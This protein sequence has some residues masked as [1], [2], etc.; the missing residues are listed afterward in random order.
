[1]KPAGRRLTLIDCIP[2]PDRCKLV[3]P[4]QKMPPKSIFRQPGARHFQ[5]VHRSQRDPLIHDPDASNHV[6][7][8]FE[9][10]NQ[11]VC[12]PLTLF[13]QSKFLL[14]LK[15]C[16]SRV[17]PAPSLSLTTILLSVLER[18]R[19]LARLQAMESSSMTP[20][21]ITCNTSNP[22]GCKKTG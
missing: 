3:Q 14:L 7:K 5:L 20:S 12:L 2:N 8:E 17:K 10:D 6:L 22:S 21:T 13:I 1:M 15:T 19:T 11:K 16:A 4:H 9:R 18:G